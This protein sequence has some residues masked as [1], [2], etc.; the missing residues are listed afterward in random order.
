[1]NADNTELPEYED[2]V[3]YTL[4]GLNDIDKASAALEEIGDLQGMMFTDGKKGLIFDAFRTMTQKGLPVNYDSVVY[5][6]HDNRKSSEL[7]A[8]VFSEVIR[9]VVSK[10]YFAATSG[11]DTYAAALRQAYLKRRLIAAAELVKEDIYNAEGRTAET[12]L[13]TVMTRFER[14]EDESFDIGDERISVTAGVDQLVK[15]I[16]SGELKDTGVQTGF[17]GIDVLLK[18]LKGGQMILIAARPGMGK[19]A[20]ALNMAQFIAKAT[21]GDKPLMFFSLEMPQREI[22]SRLICTEAQADL[23]HINDCFDLT[24]AQTTRMIQGLTQYVDI[25]EANPMKSKNKLFF[26]FG[27]DLTPGRI[28]LECQKLRREQGLGCVVIDYLQYITPDRRRENRNLEVSDISHSI[29]A[30]A[31]RF[32]V[33]VIALAQLNRE[34]DSRG[35]HVPV[36]SDLRDSGSLEQDADV[37]MFLNREAAYPAKKGRGEDSAPMSDEDKKKATLYIT[38][39]R[40]G[41]SGKVDLMYEGPQFRFYEPE[42]E[43]GEL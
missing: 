17:P 30:L 4:L 37:I 10:S 14:V 39:N 1:M 33:P 32:D 42:Q 27:D 13:A 6:L 7:E 9:G 18:G 34:I 19:S 40:N 31:K 8:D 29:K 24:P 23:D 41:Q 22:I 16:K 3:L 38:K 5:Y 12:L 36:N 20:L 11:L 21:T 15:E 25:N 28:T 2:I 26:R 35:D 43:R